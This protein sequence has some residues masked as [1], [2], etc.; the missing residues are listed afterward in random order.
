[1]KFLSQKKMK[2]VSSPVTT[3]DLGNSFILKTFKK[4]GFLV[5]SSGL[6]GVRGMWFLKHSK[7]GDVKSLLVLM[8][9]SYYKRNCEVHFPVNSKGGR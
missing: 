8:R 4:L 3:K 6:Y 1:M 5:C 7:V 9:S 2:S